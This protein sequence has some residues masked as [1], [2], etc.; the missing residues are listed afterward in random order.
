M[1]TNAFVVGALPKP[2]WLDYWGPFG[3][4]GWSRTNSLWISLAVGLMWFG[5]VGRLIC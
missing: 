3:R 1:N 2:H 5:L 4:L